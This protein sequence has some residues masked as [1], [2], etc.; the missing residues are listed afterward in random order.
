MGSVYVE[1]RKGCR[2]ISCSGWKTYCEILK[3]VPGLIP[4][5]LNGEYPTWKG[6][7][8]DAAIAKLEEHYGDVER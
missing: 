8:A 5:T 7:Y 2:A 4:G 3:D 6:F 1:Q